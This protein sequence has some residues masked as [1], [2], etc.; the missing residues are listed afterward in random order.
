M[1]IKDIKDPTFLNTMSIKELEK[2]SDEIRT[3]LI[4]SLSKTGGHLSS[5]LGIVELTIALHYMFS[6]PIDKIIFDVG[7]QS[8]VHKILTGRAN[9]FNTL[10][11]TDGLSGFQKLRE[12]NHDVWEAGHSSTALSAAVAMASS[13]DLSHENFEV[14]PVIGDAAM[15]GGPTLEALNHLGSTKSKVIIILNDN[16]M[17]I[18]KSVGGFGNFLGDLRLS[19]TYNH[20]KEEYRH[21][22]SQG[23]IRSKIFQTTKKMKDFIKRGVIKP[24]IFS[25]FGI[26]YLGPVD[27]HDFV[28]L[29]R[30]L[31]VAKESTESVV[32]HIVTTKGKGYPYAE[33]DACGK[34]HGIAPFDIT[35]GR[36]L[37]KNKE[38]DIGW[39][40]YIS[41]HLTKHMAKDQKIVAITPAMIHGSSL[42][43][44]FEQYPERSFDV[45]IAEEHAVTFM[46]GLSLQGKK[47]FLS[48]YSSFLQRA[49]DQINHDIARMNLPCLIAIDRAGLVGADGPTHH[50]V[51]DIS[52][53]NPIPNLVLF[54]PKD[55]PEAAAFINTAFTNYD[56]PYAFRIPRSTILNIDTSIETKLEIGSWVIETNEDTYDVTIIC[57]GDNVDKVISHFET[58]NKKI[59]VINARFIKPMDYL[60][61]DDLLDD[62]KPLIIYETDLKT[63]GLGSNIAYYFLQRGVNKRIYSLG[64]EDHYTKQGSI[65]DLLQ[66]EKIDMESLQKVVEESTG[67]KRKN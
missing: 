37:V 12:S 41:N 34:W 65:S 13:R 51:F 8:Y 6:S 31:Q 64:I 15:V 56:R 2:L 60:M 11:K 26:E 62:S 61:L 9:L 55:G 44:V 16:Q 23:T 24:S 22:F 18:G 59:R 1:N 49:Y 47:P 27:G 3:F 58:Y 67:D 52:F 35:T 7:H 45:G 42:E 63:G 5:N 50:G 54:A 25:E 4:A 21:L 57:Y 38:G 48:I 43:N 66:E 10:R 30:A 53:L 20:L 36:A 33:T 29:F 40:E 14:I 39:S 17:A 32:V 19:K 28:E 46:A